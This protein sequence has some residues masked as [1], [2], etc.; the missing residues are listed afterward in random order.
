MKR[1]LLAVPV[2]L[3]LI[4]PAGSLAAS[5][6]GRGTHDEKMR[7]ELR[8]R[9]DKVRQFSVEHA[10]YRCNEGG[11]FRSGFTAERIQIEGRRFSFKKTKQFDDFKGTA[12]IEGT[13]RRDGDKVVG[14]MRETR[15]GGGVRCTTGDEPYRARR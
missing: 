3:A 11:S 2:A 5:Y 7:V 6:E 8:T 9:G 10:R 1:V 4:A 12:V 14:T 15:R 13:F